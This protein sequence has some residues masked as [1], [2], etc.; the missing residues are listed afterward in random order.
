MILGLETL[1]GLAALAV[2]FYHFPSQSLLFI[3]EGHIAVYLFFSLSGFVITLNYFKKIDNVKSLIFFQKKRFFRLYPIHF[4]VLILVLLIQCLKFILIELGLQS[5]GPAFGGG[6]GGDSWYTLR[7][8]ILHIFLLQA[9]LDYGYFLSW[10]GAAWTISVEFYTYFVF[11]ILT[12]ISFRKSYI[13]ISLLI[14]YKIY[15]T[16]IFDFIYFYL[17]IKFHPMFHGCLSFFFTGSLMF[18]IYKKIKFR[19][20]DFVFFAFLFIFFYLFF[21]N[22]IETETFFSFLI[23]LV[24]LLKNN[25]ISYKILNYQYLVYLGTVSYSFYMIHQVVLYIFIQILKLLGLG[26]SFSENITGATTGSV[27]YDT[28]ITISYTA[29]SIF[30]AIYMYK[31]IE[32]KFRIKQL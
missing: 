32:K 9:V 4:F 14:L 8:F 6:A 5:G 27:F 29:I 13:F 7:D 26:Y 24:A 25:S 30:I 23:L 15:N 20:N 1:R 19:L 18:F 11:G 16:N 12:L 3:Q 31:Y 22:Y 2:A 21:K 17:N 28:V 10:N